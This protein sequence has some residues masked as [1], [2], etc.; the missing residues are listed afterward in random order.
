[1]VVLDSNGVL[2][3]QGSQQQPQQ[4]QQQQQQQARNMQNMPYHHLQ[5]VQ[6]LPSDVSI[7]QINHPTQL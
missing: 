6:P 3:S 2:V 5:Y 1:M 7:T 4:Q